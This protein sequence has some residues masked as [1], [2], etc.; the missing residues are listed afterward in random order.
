MRS[1]GQ[2]HGAK[3]H[4]LVAVRTRPAIDTEA[5]LQQL[6]YDVR[7]R[8]LEGAG[9]ALGSRTVGAS[10]AARLEVSCA[11]QIEAKVVINLNLVF[12]DASV[13]KIELKD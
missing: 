4:S 7:Q 1:G 9:A 13:I 8:A 5:P 12:K 2:D 11:V 3:S 10:I 6:K